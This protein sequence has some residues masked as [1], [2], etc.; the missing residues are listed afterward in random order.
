MDMYS[1]GV[2]RRE[3]ELLFVTKC[4]SDRIDVAMSGLL[5]SEAVDVRHMR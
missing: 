2:L 5:K 4:S 1:Q 3:E